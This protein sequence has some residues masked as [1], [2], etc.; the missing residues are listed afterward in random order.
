MIRSALIHQAVLREHALG[1]EQLRELLAVLGAHAH[2]AAQQE[3]V[4]GRVV[5]LFGVGDDL[6]VLARLHVALHDLGRDEGA[7][8]DGEGERGVDGLDQVAQLLARFQLLLLQPPLQQLRL[9]LLDDGLAEL[10]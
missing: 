3:G 5:D 8:V 6:G 7:R 1:H 2:H 10:D 4:V 9:A